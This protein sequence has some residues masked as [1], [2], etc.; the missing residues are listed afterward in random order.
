[1]LKNDRRRVVCR[2]ITRFAGAVALACTVGDAALTSSALGAASSDPRSAVQTPVTRGVC[3]APKTRP[4]AVTLAT[5]GSGVL[6]GFSHHGHVRYSH[7]GPAANLHWTSWT[8]TEG[9]ASGYLWVDDGDPSIGTG[10]FYAV[11]ASIR[12]WRPVGGVFTRLTIVPHGSPSFHPNKDWVN[13][14]PVTYHAQRCGKQGQWS[15]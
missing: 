3:H 2:V 10:T 13:P 4:G 7:G 12:V 5:D 1:M 6:A 8:A 11:P 15:W 14:K 9:R